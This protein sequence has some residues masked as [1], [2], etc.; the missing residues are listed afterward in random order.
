MVDENIKIE[1]PIGEPWM[2]LH[3]FEKVLRQYKKDPELEV[4]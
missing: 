4:F 2:D 1:V 3:F